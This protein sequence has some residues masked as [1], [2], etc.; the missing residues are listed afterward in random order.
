MGN[1][2]AAAV[3]KGEPYGFFTSIKG[4]MGKSLYSLF[5]GC[6]EMSR[7]HFEETGPPDTIPSA[8]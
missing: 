6:D 2:R 8:G 7:R 1:I 5:T 4:C 3:K